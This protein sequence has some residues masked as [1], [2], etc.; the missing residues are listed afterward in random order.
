MC[1]IL[2]AFQI[3]IISSVYAFYYTSVGETHF[4]DIRDITNTARYLL[5]GSV[6]PLAVSS[7]LDG[8][9]VSRYRRAISLVCVSCKSFKLSEEFG[10]PQICRTSKGARLHE[11]DNFQH[12]PMLRDRNDVEVRRNIMVFPTHSSYLLLL[13]QCNC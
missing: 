13:D 7:L 9:V 3:N 11:D 2:I 8:T 6:V 10:K 5:F 12:A 1:S 4:H